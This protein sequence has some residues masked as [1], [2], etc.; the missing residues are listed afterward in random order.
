MTQRSTDWFLEFGFRVS[1]RDLYYWGI[2]III[3]IIIITATTTLTT[4]IN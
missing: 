1:P 2:K 3:I 4:R